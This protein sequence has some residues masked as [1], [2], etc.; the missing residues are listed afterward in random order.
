MRKPIFFEFILLAA[1]WGSSF[2][3]TRVSAVEF[4]VL[5]TAAMRVGLAALFLGES[6]TLWMLLCGCVIVCGTALATG[7]VKIKTFERTS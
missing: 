2:L 4:G 5:P 7:L 3:F 6:I 1:I